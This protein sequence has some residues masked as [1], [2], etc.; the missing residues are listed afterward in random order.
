MKRILVTG[1]SGYFGEILVKKLIEKN[2]MVSILDINEP[3]S[4]MLKKVT[5]FM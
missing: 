1:G 4:D 3:N 5:F 2:F